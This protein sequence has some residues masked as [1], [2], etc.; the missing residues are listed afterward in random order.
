MKF[1]TFGLKTNKKI[2]MLH[3]GGLSWWALK[4][5]IDIFKEE[6]YIVTPIIDG[7]G[8]DGDTDFISIEN[9]ADKLIDYIDREMG[10]SLYLITGLSIGAQIV[11]EVLG[12]RKNIAE[13][14]ILESALVIPMKRIGRLAEMAAFFSHNLVKYRSFSEIQAKTLSLP[15]DMLENYYLDGM[16]MSKNSLVNMIRSNSTYQMPESI[17]ESEAE[18]LI[19]YG[20]KEPKIIIKSAE[21]LSSKIDGSKKYV[22]EGMGHGEISLKNGEI[23]REILDNFMNNK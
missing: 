9:S 3:G 22:A 5:L 23:Y 16:K 2:V 15:S 21:L 4:P 18:I 20:S 1:K 8:E 17:I 14:A 10:G 13:K 7:H 6:Y 11:C 19:V 12:R